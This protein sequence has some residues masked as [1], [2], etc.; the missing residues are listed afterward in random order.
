MI[1]N[2]VARPDLWA[3]YIL[4]SYILTVGGLVALMLWSYLSMRSAEKR[5]DQLKRK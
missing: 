3:S 1:E 2:M 4:P 5:S